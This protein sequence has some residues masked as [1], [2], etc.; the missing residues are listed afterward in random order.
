VPVNTGSHANAFDRPTGAYFSLDGSTVYVLNCG[1]ECG[2]TTSSVTYLQQGALQYNNIPKTVPDASA[3]TNQV[4]VPGG[5]TAAVANGT[6]LY[7]SG[8]QLLSDGLFAGNLSTIDLA[9][10]TVTGK[11]SRSERPRASPICSRAHSN[12]TTF[13]RPCR[14]PPP[15]RIRSWSPAASPQPWP[16]EPRFTSLVSNCCLTASSPATFRPSISRPIPSRASTPDLND[17][18]R[19]LSAA[20]RT[21]IQQ[22][23]EDRAGRLRL[24]E[25]GPGPRRRHRSRGQRNHALRLW[26]ATAV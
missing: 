23:S 12:T 4:L 17:L 15:S 3:F 13:R 22:H 18:E 7:V 20:G 2:G 25:S 11:Y 26:S 5:V 21:P 1:P 19:H 6:T 10:N 24:H 9:T 16:T 8:Q 14:T